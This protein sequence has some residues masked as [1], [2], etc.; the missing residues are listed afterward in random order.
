[1]NHEAITP[2]FLHPAGQTIV[3]GVRTVADEVVKELHTHGVSVIEVNRSGA[4]FSYK[5][6]SPTTGA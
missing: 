2:S 6:D 3:N 4:A 1:M 5:R